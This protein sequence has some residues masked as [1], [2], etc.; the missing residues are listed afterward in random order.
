LTQQETGWPTLY[1]PR[2]HTGQATG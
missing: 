1:R 2:N